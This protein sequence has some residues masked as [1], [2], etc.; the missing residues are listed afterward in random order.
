MWGTFCLCD[1]CGCDR[2]CSDTPYTVKLKSEVRI[3]MKR[4]LKVCVCAALVDAV[5]LWFAR[6][7]HRSGTASRWCLPGIARNTSNPCVFSHVLPGGDVGNFFVRRVWS[8]FVWSWTRS[9]LYKIE[10]TGADRTEMPMA[11]LVDAVPL[12]SA[13]GSVSPDRSPIVVE[14]ALVRNRTHPYVLLHNMLRGGDVGNLVCATGP[15]AIYCA[16]TRRTHCKVESVQIALLWFLHVC[17]QP[18]LTHL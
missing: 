9:T 5:V 1:G 8:L 14:V 3:A 18:W 15:A 12:W 17:L 13:E 6:I 11:V 7:A 16:R 4:L 2:L 10:F